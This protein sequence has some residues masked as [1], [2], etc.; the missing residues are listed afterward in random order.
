MSIFFRLPIIR[1]P[2]CLTQSS[3]YVEQLILVELQNHPQDTIPLIPRRSSQG[4]TSTEEGP[5]D[6]LTTAGLRNLVEQM[7]RSEG[8]TETGWDMGMGLGVHTGAS[9]GGSDIEGSGA[10]EEDMNG[11][12]G[13]GG[14]M[15]HYSGATGG[16]VYRDFGAD[17]YN[18][19]G[20]GEPVH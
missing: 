5:S 2:D 19:Q 3:R 4:A 12:A 18:Q 17:T 6:D 20:R 15:P 16:G 11:S 7:A 13:I 8:G 10:D 14:M 1:D 9:G